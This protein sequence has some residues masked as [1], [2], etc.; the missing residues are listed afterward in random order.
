MQ[1]PTL[2]LL[3]L[4]LVCPAK[5]EPSAPIPLWAE[6]VPGEAGV[7]LPA[8]A[9]T[10]RGENRIEIVS[11]VS[12]PTLTWY[13]APEG[14]NTGAAV[15][16]CPGGGY[17]VLAYAHEGKEVCTWLNGIGVNAG[18]LKYRVPRREGLPKHQAPLQDV[19]RAI[20]MIRSREDGKV[21]PGRVGI[22]GF[23]AGGHLSVMALTSDGTRTY[24]VDP[25]WDAVNPVPDFGILVYPAYLQGES[26]P[27]RLAEDVEVTENTPPVFIVVAHGDRKWVEGSALFYLAMRRKDREA[28]LHIYGKGVHGF[29]LANTA[30]EVRHWPDLAAAWMESMGY[31]SAPTPTE[32]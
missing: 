8:E 14:N 26:D 25:R 30:E 31:L 28:E 29:G 16:V 18:L 22:L 5:A 6:E 1:S 13:P 10:L 27:D 21:D 3:T 9:V 15:L 12:T 24:P 2:L 19:Q 11:H 4:V 17:H 7:S 32:P 20:G 23:S